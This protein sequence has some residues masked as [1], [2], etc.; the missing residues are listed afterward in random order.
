MLIDEQELGL[1]EAQR[2]I[3]SISRGMALIFG[4]PD[5][6]KLLLQASLA[7]AL[8]TIPKSRVAAWLRE[9][10]DALETRSGP[11]LH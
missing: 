2:R 7:L 5:T 9:V 6:I 3:S 8:T 10:A 4:A 11:T 1:D